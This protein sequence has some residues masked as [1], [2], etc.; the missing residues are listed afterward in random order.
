L[1]VYEGK[2]ERTV[3]HTGQQ[4]PCRYEG[5]DLVAVQS[6]GLQE[7]NATGWMD[8]NNGLAL[9]HIIES[10]PNAIPLDNFHWVGQQHS[11]R[12]CQVVGSVVA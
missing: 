12:H 3:P 8:E 4:F 1:H 2:S 5:L 11:K 9:T 6:L 7:P 10:K